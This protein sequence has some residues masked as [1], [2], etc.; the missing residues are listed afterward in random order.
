MKT[1]YVCMAMYDY[2]HIKIKVFAFLPDSA[3]E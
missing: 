2:Y 1:E 3:L